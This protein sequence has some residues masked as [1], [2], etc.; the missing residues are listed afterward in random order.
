MWVNSNR[1]KFAPVRANSFTWFK[2]I[3]FALTIDI[4]TLIIQA[5]IRMEAKSSLTLSFMSR[6]HHGWPLSATE[7]QR[8][9][10]P[11]SNL[12]SSLFH[13]QIY[14]P[15]SILNSID[16]SLFHLHIYPPSSILKSSLL[17][18]QIW[19]NPFIFHKLF[20]NSADPDKYASKGQSD[21]CW[22]H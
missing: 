19:Q 8:Q 2:H 14:P 3:Y 13:L 18:L 12:D 5:I 10:P 16:S 7:V 11:S 17:H 9:T 20:R 4:H 15:S 6:P 21:P 1:K 22:H